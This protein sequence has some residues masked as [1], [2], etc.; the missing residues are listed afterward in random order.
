MSTI[1]SAIWATMQKRAR[2][3]EGKTVDFPLRP[4]RSVAAAQQSHLTLRLLRREDLKWKL[5]RGGVAN[6]STI[7]LSK[8]IARSNADVPR[9]E[10]SSLSAVQPVSRP[11]Q[12]TALHDPTEP[13]CLNPQALPQRRSAPD[14]PPGRQGSIPRRLSRNTGSAHPRQPRYGLTVRAT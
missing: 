11:W 12:R 5:V 6:T 3:W 9:W 2:Y 8:I 14:P 10:P 4:D 13:S 1:T 7:S